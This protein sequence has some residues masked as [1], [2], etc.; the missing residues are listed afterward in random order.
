M[1]KPEQPENKSDTPPE[2]TPEGKNLPITGKDAERLR[3][4]ME[5]KVSIQ[6][7]V[8]GTGKALAVIGGAATRGPMSALARY[9]RPE[10]NARSR[11]TK[12]M[13]TFRSVYRSEDR[14][15][16]RDGS[17][18]LMGRNKRVML[19]D[20]GTDGVSLE[21]ADLSGMSLRL[22]PFRRT[23]LNGAD[24]RGA[25][26]KDNRFDNSS[27]KSALFQNATLN[28][29]RF[30]GVDLRGADFSGATIKGYS[31]GL[32]GFR[33]ADLRG[34]NFTG[35]RFKSCLGSYS[36][37]V[38]MNGADLEGA[39]FS[40]NANWQRLDLRHAKNVDKAIVVDRRGNPIPGARL[41]TTGG[42]IVDNAPKA[43]R[44][45][46]AMTPGL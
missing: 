2:G 38:S 40:L 37:K 35:T 21:N 6:T 5:R 17:V 3:N 19:A 43:D 31:D 29:P 9:W 33:N 20:A 30:H 7:V 26:L 42:V 36:E 16:R 28:C 45:G 10:G 32:D 8:E 1:T 22:V 39:V 13:E 4:L 27:L 25:D 44:R 41:M 23:N 15:F 46:P 14:I 34:A 11:G 24:F 18:L 12:W